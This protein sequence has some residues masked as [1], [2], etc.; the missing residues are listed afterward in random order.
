MDY[1]LLD[2]V[3]DEHCAGNRNRMALRSW[4]E[5]RL[6]NPGKDR[7]GALRC[8]GHVNCGNNA[9]THTRV[10][11]LRPGDLGQHGSH[12]RLPELPLVEPAELL[13]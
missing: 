1:Y 6:A 13:I 7:Y 3:R 9:L 4:R 2:V 11:I 12:A 8:L 5:R 10:P